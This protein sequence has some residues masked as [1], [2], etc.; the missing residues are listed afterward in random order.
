MAMK[1]RAHDTFFIRKGWLSKGMK[2][3]QS[4]PDV[5]IAKDENPNS[6]RV[7]MN[8]IDILRKWELYIFFITNCHRARKKQPLGT[9][10]SMSS[11][12]PN[13]PVMISSVSCSSVF[14][15][16]KKQVMWLY[17]H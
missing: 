17:A 3:V 2:Y 6:D 16:K 7:F 9:T 10:F 14:E 15:W 8:T 4:K 13:L 11:I 1:F 12:C 5:F